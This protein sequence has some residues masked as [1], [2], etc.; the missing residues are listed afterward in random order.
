MSDA[1]YIYENF[2]LILRINDSLKVFGNKVLR[3]LFG[4]RK[5][6]VTGYWKR[7]YDGELRVIESRRM[8]QVRYMAKDK[9]IHDLYGKI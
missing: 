3:R 6:D 2:S 7:L 9:Y 1:L 5:E 4:T 8:W